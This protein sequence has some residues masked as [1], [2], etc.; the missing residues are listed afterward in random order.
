MLGGLATQA[1][2]RTQMKLHGNAALSLNKR[3]LLARRVVEEGW[4]LTSAAAAAEVSVPTTRKRARRYRAERQAG[5]LD[6]PSAARRGPKGATVLRPA[7]WLCPPRPGQADPNRHKE[8]GEDRPQGGRPQG[9]RQ[10][11]QQ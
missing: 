11:A 6:R 3:K 4:S 10:E 1:S 7:S 2:R 5:P 9:H 8:A